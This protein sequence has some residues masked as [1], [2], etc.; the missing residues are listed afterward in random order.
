MNTESGDPLGMKVM[1]NSTFSRPSE[2]A[3]R[4]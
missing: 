2:L 3:E 1:R 4:G